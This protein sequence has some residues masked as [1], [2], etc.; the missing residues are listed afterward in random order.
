MTNGEWTVLSFSAKTKEHHYD[1]CHEPI[2]QVVFTLKLKRRPMYFFLYL[3]FPVIAI[4][5]LSMLIFKIPA[6]SG[7]RIGFGV[8]VLL[9]MGVYLMVISQD[10]PRKADKA[11]LVGVLYVTLFYVMVLGVVTGAINATFA[12]KTSNPPEWLYGLVLKLKR[13]KSRKVAAKKPSVRIQKKQDKF[14]VITE[15]EE[16]TDLESSKGL[17]K[18]TELDNA[19][20]KK[21][22]RP[23]LRSQSSMHCTIQE[24]TE[25]DIDNQMKWQEIAYYSD[26]IFF[27]LYLTLIL[28]ASGSVML[29]LQL[30]YT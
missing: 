18:E 16:L 5:L 3:I 24:L 15:D 26:H 28:V 10:L 20:F 19:D 27:W 8:T 29:G 6:Q 4:V 9:T 17:Q 14:P 30:K 21:H 25:E 22:A 2:S 13:R 23:F 1:C 7:E 11:P 12:Y